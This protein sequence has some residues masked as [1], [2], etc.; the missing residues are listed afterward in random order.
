M[1]LRNRFEILPEMKY[2]ALSDTIFDQNKAVTDVCV[3]RM[4]CISVVTHSESGTAAHGTCEGI[5]M[6]EKTK[7]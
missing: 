7:A 5:V 2:D 6:K 4:L 3:L 1:W